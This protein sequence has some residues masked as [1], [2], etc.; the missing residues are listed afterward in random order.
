VA[1]A[2]RARPLPERLAPSPLPVRRKGGSAPPTPP[3]SPEAH[4]SKFPANPRTPTPRRRF[5][6]RK[7]PVV[8]APRPSATF[9]SPR[10]K[11]PRLPIQNSKFKIQNSKSIIPISSPLSP[12]HLSPHPLA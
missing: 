3:L 4:S 8:P 7:P 12:R 9:A 1:G 6:T 2:S 11:N 10:L 5:P